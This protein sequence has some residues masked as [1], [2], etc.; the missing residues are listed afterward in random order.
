LLTWKILVGNDGGRRFYL[1]LVMTPLGF[2]L[3]AWLAHSFFPGSQGSGIPQ[4]IAA[5]HLREEQ[6][7]GHLLSLR[8]A[9]EKFAAGVL[10]MVSGI[11]GG[12]F[13][14]SLAVGAG[15]GSTL[16][17]ILASST[18]RAALLGMAGYFAGVMQAPM[19]AFAIISK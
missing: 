19:T 6:G 16:G 3:C 12:I 11:A 17:L 4:A 8:P 13:A 2:V 9:A 10:S 1:P 18:G 15:L 7:R 5:R 14:P